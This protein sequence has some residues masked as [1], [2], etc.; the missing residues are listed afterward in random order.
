MASRRKKL[1]DNSQLAKV[2]REVISGVV[3]FETSLEFFVN[4]CNKRNLR[5][6]TIK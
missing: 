5:P 6:Y 3:D 4:D 1:L 2:T